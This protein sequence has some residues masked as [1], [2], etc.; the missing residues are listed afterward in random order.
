MELLAQAETLQIN[1]GT[2]L[3]AL[4]PTGILVWFVWYKTSVSDPA[5]DKQFTE[6]LDKIV[7]D[8]RLELREERTARAAE[9]AAIRQAF[10]CRLTPEAEP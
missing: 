6:T 7:S 8:F 10:Q 5:K 2:I 3:G 1:W 9:V 4:G